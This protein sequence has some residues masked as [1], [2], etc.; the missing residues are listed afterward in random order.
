[1]PDRLRPGKFI[2]VRGQK[3]RYLQVHVVGFANTGTTPGPHRAPTTRARSAQLSGSG[4]QITQVIYV[5]DL[6][7]TAFATQLQAAADMRCFQ[8]SDPH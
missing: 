4:A 8:R 6:D 3:A 2:G 1:M 5:L 7:T